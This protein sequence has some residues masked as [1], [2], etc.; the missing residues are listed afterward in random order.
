MMAALA[1]G[2]I[3]VPAVVAAV[4]LAGS[5]LVFAALLPA[6]LALV[7]PGLR[8]LDR[9]SAVPLRAL[10]LLRRLR[11]FEALEPPALE[12][13][14]RSADWVTVPAGRVIIREGERGDRFYVLE[15]GTV[16]VTRD[17][18]HVRTLD[19]A[20]DGFGEIALLRDVPRTATVTADVETTLMILT[21]EPFLAA[22]TRHPVV[23]AAAGR[24][25]EARLLADREAPPA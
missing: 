6:F 15:S 18:V 4:G 11:L 13:L 9:R 3:L 21:R 10:T 16:S 23:V 24:V 12:G 7:W 25:V 2:S 22:V 5:V 20:G 19:A 8:A 1:T 14:A 17:G